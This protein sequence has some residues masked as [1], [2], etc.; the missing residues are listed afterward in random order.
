[1]TTDILVFA[2]Q[3]LEVFKN[4]IDKNPSMEGEYFI[5]DMR[6]D[7][8]GSSKN[9]M[10]SWLLLRLTI[11]HHQYTWQQ[12]EALDPNVRGVLIRWIPKRQKK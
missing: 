6:M 3:Q 7:E 12:S 10:L 8:Y 2:N 9:R 1:M 5:D 11:T 4:E